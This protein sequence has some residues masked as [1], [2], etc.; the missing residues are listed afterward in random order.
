MT[1]AAT[2]TK[3]SDAAAAAKTSGAR[4]IPRPTAM[5][6]ELTHRCPLSCPYCSNPVEM[7]KRDAELDTDQWLGVF[8]QAAALGV[9]HVHLS[10]GE[11]ASRR[12]LEDLTEGASKAGLYTNLITSGIG[13]TKA[14]LTELANRGLD[15]VQLSIQGPTAP[16]ADEI[17]GYKGGYARK[18]QVAEWIAEAELPLTVNAVMH[19]RNLDRL[20]ETIELAVQL[21][22][23]R[24][25]VAT[26]QFHGWAAK[27]IGALMPTREQVE[28][29]TAKVAAERER[30]KGVP[31]DRL[32][33]GPTTMRAIRRR[34]WAA[35]GVWGWW[36]DRTARRC[37]ATPP[38]ASPIWFSI[39]SAN[40]RSPISG[41]IRTPLTLIGAWIGCRSPVAAAIV[42]RSISVVAAARPWR[43]PATRARPI[44]PARSRRI[45]PRSAR[46][47]RRGRPP[48]TRSSTGRARDAVANELLPSD[49]R[50]L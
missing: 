41:R 5:L 23:R 32:C 14:R 16:I 13:V 27:N 26:V 35:G 43:S 8:K 22:A 44:R 3:N 40:A 10:G 29:T 47:P 15:H 38:I 42:A 33:P 19:R 30:L 50:A 34:A 2:V 4:A 36:S 12:D 6:A 11:P 9:I 31:G 17:G 7:T 24:L 25:E 48:T 28:R 37:R 20:D 21:G 39:R 49:R 45:T 46:A 18:M 1:D